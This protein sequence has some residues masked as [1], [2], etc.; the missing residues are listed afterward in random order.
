E[1]LDSDT[2]DAEAPIEDQPLPDDASPIALSLGYVAD[3][4]LEED[5]KEDPE[6]DLADYPVDGGDNDD[7]ESSD[8]DDDDDDDDEE[9]EASEDDDKDE[10]E[11]PAL[12]DSSDVP[13]DDH[14]PSAEDIE[15]FETDES[16][17]IHVPSPRRHRA[18][19]SIRPQTLM[20]AATKALIVVVAAALPLLPPPS[21]LTLLS[22]LLP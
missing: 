3:S 14:V 6:E 22:Y 17:P 7:D 19:I 21:L 12:A 8:D 1:Y 13:V 9:Q 20:L 15:A 16:A 11:H 18:R 5:P 2:S 10:E 4:N